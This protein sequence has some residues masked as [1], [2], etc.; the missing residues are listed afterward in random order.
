MEISTINPELIREFVDKII[1]YQ[2][3]KV[4]G[5]QGQHIKSITTVSEQLK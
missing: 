1:V 4:N 3:K 2:A 5:K